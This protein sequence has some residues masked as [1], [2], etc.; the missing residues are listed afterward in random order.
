MKSGIWSELVRTNLAEDWWSALA[1]AGGGWVLGQLIHRLATGPLLKSA[2]R[3]RSKADEELITALRAPLVVIVTILGIAMGYQ[4]LTWP[5]R[6][7]LWITRVLHVG[8]ALA[9]TW[10]VSRI[11]SHI[12]RTVMDKEGRSE[13]TARRI[14][15]ALSGVLSVLIWGLGLVVALSNAGYDVGALLAGIGIGGLAMAMAAKDTLT[16][17]F[18]G[19]T[20]FTDEPFH[21]GDRIR[22]GEHTGRVEAIGL[23]STRLRTL[24]G[25]VVVIPNHMFTESVVVNL[26]AEPSQRVRLDIGLV[27]ETSPD[28]VERALVI[29]DE[30]VRSEQEWLEPKHTACLNDLKAD[31]LGVL[32]IYHVRRERPLDQARTR[33][34]L[35]VLRRFRSEGLRFAYPTSL[36]YAVQVQQS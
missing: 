10:T 28:R 30:L 7:D 32:F 9:V 33:I 2:S 12:L 35:L 24:E 31:Q 20:I 5:E 4:Q 21:T 26:S 29:L 1:F 6:S 22:V 36:Q 34:N 14:V 23:R 3:T 19:I 16:N 17:V 15:P 11:V 8:I 27:C 18:G 25:P 13:S